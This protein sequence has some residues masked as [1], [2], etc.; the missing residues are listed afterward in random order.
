MLAETIVAHNYATLQ[1]TIL[2]AEFARPL[3]CS[4]FHSCPK[5][6]ELVFINIKF[7]ESVKANGSTTIPKPFVTNFGQIH[8]IC[9]KVE[10]FC[11]SGVPMKYVDYIKITRMSNLRDL[12]LLHPLFWASDAEFD[13]FLQILISKARKLDSLALGF[14]TNIRKKETKKFKVLRKM[15]KLEENDPL[16]NGAICSVPECKSGFKSRC[17]VRSNCYIY[18]PVNSIHSTQISRNLKLFNRKMSHVS[19]RSK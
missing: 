12:S 7:P 19:I 2:Q 15:L 1:T 10:R 13:R 3:D 11:N 18:F 6:K 14:L 16:K 4:I 5:L 9:P 17:I 8:R